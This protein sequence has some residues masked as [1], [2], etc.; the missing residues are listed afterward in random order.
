MDKTFDDYVNMLN[1]KLG[2]KL[3]FVE[4]GAMDGVQHDA[5]HKHIVD[6]PGWKGVLVE[7]LP[8]MFAKLKQ[9]YKTHEN[10]KL[11]NAAITEHIG[12]AQITRIPFD[13]VNKEAP[14]WADGIATLKPEIHIISRYENLAPYAVQEPIKTIT[15]AALAEKH[16]ITHIDLLQIDTEGYDKVIFDQIWLAGFRPSIIKLET[17]YLLHMTILELLALL[18]ANGYLCTLQGEDLIAARM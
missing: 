6:N 17:L 10:L 7:P 13:K 11:E 9:T 14:S 3:F 1:D 16:Q 12:R 18:D 2:G 5:L 4:I 15:F 8:D